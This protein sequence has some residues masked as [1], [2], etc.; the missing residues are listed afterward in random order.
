M[1]DDTLNQ[2]TPANAV[3]EPDAIEP[4]SAPEGEELAT[5]SV[6]STAAAGEAMEA[7]TAA[8]SAEDADESS[9]EG[10][11]E[12]FEETPSDEDDMEASSTAESDDTSDET[13]SALGML[14]IEDMINRHMSDMAKSREELK[15][16]KDSYE[17]SFKNDAK[18]REFEDK[19][20]D[21]AK[22]KNAYKQAMLKEPA[23]A[24]LSAKLDRM[25]GEVK[26]MQ[27]ALS[28]YLREYNRATGLMQF[29]TQDGQVLEIVQV[30]KLVKR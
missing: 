28:D 26:D 4:G 1:Q 12:P 5:V 14:R 9:E 18:Y 8:G 13:N 6:A 17:D 10:P 11:V 29:E 7:A 21:A 25:K 22:Q 27:M 23:L 19:A 24:E 30:F 15:M 20:K 16:V 3:T 2:Q